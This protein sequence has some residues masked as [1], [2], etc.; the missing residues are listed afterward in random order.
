MDKEDIIFWLLI[1]MLVTGMLLTVWLGPRKS[2]HG[3]GSAFNMRPPMSG[4]ITRTRF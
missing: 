2:K 4:K 1:A 3:Y